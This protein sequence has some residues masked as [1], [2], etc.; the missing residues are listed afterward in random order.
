MANQRGSSQARYRMR[1]VDVMVPHLHQIHVIRAITRHPE[2][3]K[4]GLYGQAL[5]DFTN[6]DNAEAFSALGEF[7]HSDHLYER[8]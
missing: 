6:G 4:E 3:D 5:A 2:I 1:V 8:C 7:V